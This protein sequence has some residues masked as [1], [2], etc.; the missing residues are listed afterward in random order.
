MQR[1]LIN[2]ENKVLKEIDHNHSGKKS[3]TEAYIVGIR[4]KDKAL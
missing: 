4:I 1:R 3:E 2:N